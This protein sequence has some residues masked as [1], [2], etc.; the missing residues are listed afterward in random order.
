MLID[1]DDDEATL[2]DCVYSTRDEHATA[3]IN[4]HPIMN[5]LS[6][7]SF[8]IHGYHSGNLRI[9]APKELGTLARCEASGTTPNP[10]RHKITSCSRSHNPFRRKITLCSRSYNP[11]R[12]KITSRSRSHNPFR[13]KITSCSRSHKPFRRKITSCSRSHN[14]FRRKITSCSGSPTPF[15]RNWTGNRGEFISNL[16]NSNPT[17]TSTIHRKARKHRLSTKTD[18][19]RRHPASSRHIVTLL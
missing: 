15:H 7:L 4:E 1:A 13:R 9:F 19:L 12:R 18:G 3:S 14:P 2:K 8:I 16:A 17:D 6:I 11:F 5:I 10:F